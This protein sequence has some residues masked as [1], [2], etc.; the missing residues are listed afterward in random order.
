M[1]DMEIL[2]ASA[3]LSVV[4]IVEA[5]ILK[6]LADRDYMYKSSWMVQVTP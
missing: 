1:R 4:T 6:W 3:L 5:T 2:R